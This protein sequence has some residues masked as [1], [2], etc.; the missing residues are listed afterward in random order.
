MNA[1]LF[2][3]VMFF[4]GLSVGVLWGYVWGRRDKIGGF[5]DEGESEPFHP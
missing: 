2:G 5:F 4:V 3:L 1:A